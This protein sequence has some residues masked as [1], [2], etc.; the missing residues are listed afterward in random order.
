MWPSGSRLT[1]ICLMA[2]RVLRA[3]DDHPGDAELVRH[4][5]EALG[6][7]SLAE[8]HLHLAALGERV[9][10]PLRVGLVPRVVGKREAGEA[11]LAVRGYAVGGHEHAAADRHADMHHLVRWRLAA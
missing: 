7:E 8:R 5:A 4:G 3:G 2:L 11:R 6:E 1:K 9:E 10:A